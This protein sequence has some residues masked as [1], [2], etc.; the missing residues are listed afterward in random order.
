MLKLR[1]VVIALWNAYGP[2]IMFIIWTFATT[3]GAA[4]LMDKVNSPW[5]MTLSVIAWLFAVTA[6][7]AFTTGKICKV[8]G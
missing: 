1:N 6:L 2:V 3:F 8:R 4:F 7:W 5:L